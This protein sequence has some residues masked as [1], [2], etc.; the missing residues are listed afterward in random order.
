MGTCKEIIPSEFGSDVLSFTPDD[1]GIVTSHGVYAL[2]ADPAPSA[3]PVMSSQ[4]S[5]VSTLGWRD[6]TWVTTEGMDLLWLSIECRDGIAAISAD[7]VAIGC[8]SGR[9]IVLGFSAAEIARL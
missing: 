9:V 5:I 7:S 4:P 1:H 8:Q 3:E 6:K 2:T